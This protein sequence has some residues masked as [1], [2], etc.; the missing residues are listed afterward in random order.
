MNNRLE[1]ENLSS[2]A[3]HAAR[4]ALEFELE[5]TP[6]PGLVD[7]EDTGSHPD[8]EQ[9]IFY[10]SAQKLEA[11]FA[12]YWLIGLQV[13]KDNI[14][15]AL[16]HLGAKAEA[17]MF[18]VTGGK[19]THKGA[20]FC[21]AL[22]LAATAYLKLT[23]SLPQIESELERIQRAA[24]Y[25]SFV[26]QISGDLVE[27]DLGKTDQEKVNPAQSLSARSFGEEIYLQ[28][29]I[30]GIRAEVSA[31]FPTITR[32]GLNSLEIHA[33]EYENRHAA[34]FGGILTE[35]KKIAL[36]YLL[37]LIARAEDTNLIKRGGLAGLDY[38]R[39]RAVFYLREKANSKT[40]EDDLRLMNA[41]FI[42][43]NLSPG[44]AADL[45]A[46]THLSFSLAII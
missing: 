7:Q 19:N 34:R 3:A 30:G 10:L 1:L 6:K 31:G 24:M 12:R 32:Y 46:L 39:E 2:L 5:L 14:L 26:P 15:P 27:T 29:G 42:K 8:M 28:H 41:E 37:T 18:A 43:R 21:F 36:D 25:L 4:K 44:G 9:R 45:L 17:E 23:A 35:N 22:L 16:R 20:H 40:W 33:F 13:E 11:Y 38:A